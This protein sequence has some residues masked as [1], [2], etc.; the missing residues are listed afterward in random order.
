M[1][2]TDAKSRTL[3]SMFGRPDQSN[4]LSSKAAGKKR[5]A[6]EEDGFESLDV[7]MDGVTETQAFNQ[8]GQVKI[9]ETECMLSSIRDLRSEIKKRKHNSECRRLSRLFSCCQQDPRTDCLVFPTSLFSK[10]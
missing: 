7:E 3:D 6:P 10:L 9:A 5:S 2:R 1:V 4:S 8:E